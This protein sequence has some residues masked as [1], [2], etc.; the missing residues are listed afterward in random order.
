MRACSPSI[1][2]DEMYI[3]FRA[4]V[5]SASCWDTGQSGLHCF[6]GSISRI[7]G[8]ECKNGETTRC[9]WHQAHTYKRSAAFC[10]DKASCFIGIFHRPARTCP[11]LLFGEAV[12]SGKFLSH[13]FESTTETAN[14]MMDTCF[15]R[16]RN[17]A[18][19]RADGWTTI[20]FAS[21]GKKV[22]GIL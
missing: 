4:F 19:A 6:R 3:E 10:L 5:D 16:V 2:K 15:V 17:Y 13:A 1:R 22:T 18:R 8:Y 9:A 14:S 11:S 12:D 7:V 21:K 20:V